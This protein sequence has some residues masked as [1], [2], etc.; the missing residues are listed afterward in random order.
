MTNPARSTIDLE[1]NKGGSAL[2]GLSLGTHDAET[3]RQEAA[4]LPP[5]ERPAEAPAAEVTRRAEPSVPNVDTYQTNANVRELRNVAGTNP[6]SE[7]HIAG[8][9]SKSE[10]ETEHELERNSLFSTRTVSKTIFDRIVH[11]VARLIKRLELRILKALKKQ[12]RRITIIDKAVEKRKA[13]IRA[14]LRQSRYHPLDRVQFDSNDGDRD[15]EDPPSGA[16]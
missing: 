7:V 16:S 2:D 8:V 9:A 11:F 15:S 6:D 1:A 4:S 3:I 10:H 14:A 5:V 12:P 13:H